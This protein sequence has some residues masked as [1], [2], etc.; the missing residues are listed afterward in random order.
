MW[1][2]NTYINQVDSGGKVMDS[3]TIQI[4]I[5]MIVYMTVVICI[6]VV[7]AKKANKNMLSILKLF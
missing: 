3:N 6:G 1:Y 2:N 4:Q 5:A 7:Y